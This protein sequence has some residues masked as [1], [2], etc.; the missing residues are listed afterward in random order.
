MKEN[1]MEHI[2]NIIDEVIQQEITPIKSG[3][4]FLD[5]T[6][7]GYYP[8]E[9]TTICG[10]INSGKTAII[11]AQINHL[12]VDQHIPTLLV[13]NNMTIESYLSCMAAY[14]CNIEADNIHSVL[15][16]E[17]YKDKVNAYLELLKEAPLYV[18]KAQWYENKPFFDKLEA[19]IEKNGIKIAFF[20]EML[21]YYNPSGEESNNL[22]KTL[23][24]SQNIP[25]VT[26][27]CTWSDR[28]GV[29]GIKPFL[30]DLC[31]Y[32]ERHGNDVVISITNYEQY[33][34]YQDERGQDLR[35]MRLM[36]ILKAKGIIDKREHLFYWD[37]FLYRDFSERQKAS[38]E[39][40][41]NSCDGR[42]DTLIKKLD[43]TIEE[44]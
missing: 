44:T 42:I 12:A 15:K 3:I 35:G 4:K 29:D 39:A 36:E 8:G 43:L 22:I 14:Y 31:E 30:R 6:L 5:E 32:G 23:A 18:V 40:I 13:L 20:D 41:R 19:Y 9:M 7:G 26:T 2:S 38:L 17:Q 27:C 37:Y 33:H 1:Q 11:I 10:D 21:V 25:I 24:L 34:I 16:S 28:E